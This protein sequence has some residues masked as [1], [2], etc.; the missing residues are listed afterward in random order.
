MCVME[1]F[2]TATFAQVPLRLTG[3]AARPI[4]VDVQNWAAYQV[5]SSALWRLG[6]WLLGV[7]LPWRFRAGKPFH[8]GLPWQLMELGL[9]IMA[10]FFAT[11]TPPPT[12]APPVQLGQPIRRG[13]AGAGRAA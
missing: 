10:R 1:Q 5:G 11:T 3:N 8:A 7:Y 6:K 12:P 13:T 4:E 2:N 9:K